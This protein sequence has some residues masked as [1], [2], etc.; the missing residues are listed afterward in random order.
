M[1]FLFQSISLSKEIKCQKEAE[2]VGISESKKKGNL[3]DHLLSVANP[4]EQ[5]GANIVVYIG[6]R[7]NY[8]YFKMKFNKKCKLI[9]MVEVEYTN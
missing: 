7:A 8:N 6:A 2:A 9:K 3:P 5:E 1:V 4:T